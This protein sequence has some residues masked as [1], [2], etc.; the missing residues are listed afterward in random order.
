[1]KRILLIIALC[2]IAICHLAK[3]TASAE[4]KNYR[5]M[6]IL[7]RGVTEAEKGFMNYFAERKIPVDFIIRDVQEDKTL[8]PGLVNE[9]KTRKPD[10]VYTFGT[11]VTAEVV[12]TIGKINPAKHV[13]DIPVV[14]NIVADPVGAELIESL[15]SSNRNLTGVSHV[16]PI[17]AQVKA[18]QSVRSFNRL[19]VIFNPQEK[20]SQLAVNELKNLAKKFKYQIDA[21]PVKLDDNGKPFAE[22]VAASMVELIN[23]KPQFIYIPSDSFL[24][25]NSSAVTQPSIGA[26][27]PTFSATEAPIREAGAMMG[28]V[29]TYYN[30]GKFAGYKAEQILVNGKAPRMIPIETLNRFTFLINM[31]TAKKVGLYPPVGVL[32][33]AEV[34]SNQ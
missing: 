14:F 11:T 1:M 5:V 15:S 21:I 29:S 6:M 34:I 7:Y 26:K 9:I 17:E 16:V 22:G 31:Q 32:R 19:G 33:F 25:K 30:V 2:Q 13:T 27:I 24:I 4:P 18:L 20:N 8:L 10:L 12:G 28:L 23:R 3:A